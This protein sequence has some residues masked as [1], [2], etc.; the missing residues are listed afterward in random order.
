MLKNK[1]LLGNSPD[2]K[3]K[4][5]FTEVDGPFFDLIKNTYPLLDS[6]GWYF[7]DNMVDFRLTNWIKWWFK[8]DGSIL[9]SGFDLCD[10]FSEWFWRY[11]QWKNFWFKKSDWT[12]FGKR[13]YFVNN[14]RNWLATFSDV[15][16]NRW[17]VNTKW[18]IIAKGFDGV[19]VNQWDLVLY[20]ENI[21]RNVSHDFRNWFSIMNSPDWIFGIALSNGSIF[22]KGYDECF[23]FNDEINWFAK[24]K[25]LWKVWYIDTNGVEYYEE[26]ISEKTYLRW[27]WKF[28]LKK[29]IKK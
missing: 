8:N 10:K 28:F 4:R 14:F 18:D 27:N 9:A 6:I 24:F 12:D 26:I 17:I 15:N 3:N 23:N 19:W 25:K 11:K 7:S 21:A 1:Q 20:A 5:V 16:W 22:K 13:F 29:L 2:L